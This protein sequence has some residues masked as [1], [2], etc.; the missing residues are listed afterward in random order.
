M[1]HPAR[2]PSARRS[3]GSG[4]PRATSRS[5]PW[6]ATGRTSTNTSSR[7][8]VTCGCTRSCPRLSRTGSPRPQQ[9]SSRPQASA[10]T[11]SCC[12]R[13]STS[14][15][16]Q[17]H[18]HQPL[19]GSRAAQGRRTSDTDPDPRRAREAP[20]PGS[21]TGT[22]FASKW[23]WRRDSAGAACRPPTPADRLSPTNHH[24][25]A[26]HRRGQTAATPPFWK[27][28]LGLVPTWAPGRAS[29]AHHGPTP[30]PPRSSRHP[31]EPIA[32][33]ATPSTRCGRR[34]AAQSS[35]VITLHR[36]VQ[37]LH[38]QTP[39]GQSSAVADTTVLGEHRHRCGGHRT[40]TPRECSAR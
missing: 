14:R 39:G 19:R 34:T 10:R 17:G 12:T 31:A 26:D 33:I 6:P 24:S 40:T 30:D 28:D 32:L 7:P 25:R 38:F 2:S 35:A 29:A 4:C 1:R 16:R 27:L 8:S 36:V 15:A 21:P 5:R 3:R 18:G 11:T 37:G 22:A 13:S 20:G 23:T 9:R